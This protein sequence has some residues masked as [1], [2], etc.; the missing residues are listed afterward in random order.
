MIEANI[1]LAADQDGA[2]LLK[3]V[4]DEQDYERARHP[5]GGP[6]LRLPRRILHISYHFHFRVTWLCKGMR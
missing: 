2:H 1:R 6:E 4:T 3:A 5:P